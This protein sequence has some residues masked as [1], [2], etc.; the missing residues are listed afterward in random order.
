MEEPRIILEKVQFEMKVHNILDLNVDKYFIEL[1]ESLTKKKENKL[2][3]KYNESTGLSDLE[4]D[5]NNENKKEDDIYF[6]Y[7]ENKY[8]S[9]NYMFCLNVL[10][11]E[12]KIC[13][14]IIRFKI[15]NKYNKE[16]WQNKKIL[17]KTKYNLYKKN[18]E[19]GTL[20]IE[21][22]FKVIKEE[23]T[24]NQLLFNSINN[25]KKVKNNEIGQIKRR[26]KK[27]IKII[28][29]EIEELKKI[30]EKENKTVP[31]YSYK[32][33]EIL[34]ILKERLNEYIKAVK[35]FREN[36]LSKDEEAFEKS[37]KIIEAKNKIESNKLIEVNINSLLDPIKP[38]FINGCSLSERESKFKE[39]INGLTNQYKEGVKN[40]LEE[41]KKI[42]KQELKDLI[43]KT[44]LEKCQNIIRALKKDI[45]NIW[46]RPPIF[47]TRIENLRLEKI[48]YNIKENCIKI[49]IGRLYDYSNNKNVYFDLQLELTKTFKENVLIEKVIEW[50]ISDIDYKN[51]YNKKL[52]VKL[53]HKNFL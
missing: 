37:Q 46:I 28:N 17:I 36:E 29:I 42:S 31:K 15:R 41:A 6:E 25:D 4:I 32:E 18:I 52:N 39:L 30:M 27:N 10:K 24:T 14:K 2:L 13:N 5:M 20:S 34:G 48:N 22:Y 7:S 45:L 19:D 23:L 12:K 53:C 50:E 8:L 38:E 26:I 16:F 51:L 35:Y 21:D 1:E 11:H 49:S 3:N 33:L 47:K 43:H 44:K 40:L 9:V